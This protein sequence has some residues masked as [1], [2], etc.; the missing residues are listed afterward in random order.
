MSTPRYIAVKVGDNYQFRR[1]DSE[2]RMK[3]GGAIAGGLVLGF[4]AMRKGGLL[5]LAFCAASAGLSYYGWTGKNPIQEIKN[6][7]S[8]LTAPEGSPSH[9]HDA[10]VESCQCASDSVDEAAMES[11]P[12]SDA[13]SHGV[14]VPA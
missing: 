6:L 13:P 8:R 2:Y 4:L 14:A 11:F 5:G 9:Q 7:K 3:A 12:A 10:Q 1:I